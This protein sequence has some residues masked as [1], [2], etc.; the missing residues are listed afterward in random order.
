MDIKTVLT[1]RLC[2]RA[3]IRTSIGLTSSLVHFPDFENGVIKLPR[4]EAALLTE[5]QADAVKKCSLI[6]DEE[7]VEGESHGSQRR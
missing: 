1:E 3:A 2:C 5:G 6:P 7:D 4:G